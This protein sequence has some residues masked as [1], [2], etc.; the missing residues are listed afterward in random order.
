MTTLI[1]KVNFKNGGS[2]PTGAITRPINEKLQDFVSVKDFG[3]I[4]DGMVDDTTSFTNAMAL[5]KAVY[6]PK[7]TYLLNFLPIISGVVL[8]GDGVSSI[9]KPLTADTY[10]CISLNGGAANTQI[11]NVSISNVKFQGDVVASA[12]SE[13]RHL[14]RVNGG[15]NVTFNECTF[16]GFRGDG[17]YIGSGDIGGDER[18]NYNITVENC[19]FDGENNDNRNGVSVIDGDGVYINNCVFKNCS[20]TDMPGAV[21]IE[22]DN[23]TFHII[24]NITVSNC[25]FYNI[26]GL[27]AC[28]LYM[29][30]LPPDPSN[31][32]FINNSFSGCTQ[33]TLG[34]TVLNTPARQ[35]ASFD[36]FVIG[37]YGYGGATPFAFNGVKGLICESNSFKSYTGSGNIGT[38]TISIYTNNLVSNSIINKNSFVNCGT[39]AAGA[40]TVSKASGLT[41]T[42]NYFSNCGNA[43]GGQLYFDTGSSDYVQILNN[44]FDNPGVVNTQG[45]WYFGHTFNVN[46]NVLFNNTFL[47]TAGASLNFP[48][49]KTDNIGDTQNIFTPSTSPTAFVPGLNTTFVNSPSGG[50][51]PG[52]YTQ[53]MLY[54]DRVVSGIGATQI[55]TSKFIP[56]GT[57]T[58][59]ESFYRYANSADTGW[60]AWRKITAT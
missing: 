24:K 6:V 12:F 52:A 23:A 16:S 5:G 48:A 58:Q 18:H 46:T 43:A 55:T 9:L 38:F 4:G 40:V 13:F 17:L 34:V 7:G 28:G 10:A 57:G 54:V 3:A 47:G 22:P 33:N 30:N 51:L 53:G 29:P 25:N 42:N 31:I 60:D 26:T 27:S 2:T 50:G 35:D 19:I 1:P 11:E 41:I 14:V 56:I 44:T 45:I 8:Y 49:F 32:N 15:R 21:D 39:S 36:I 37:N 59:T 20:R